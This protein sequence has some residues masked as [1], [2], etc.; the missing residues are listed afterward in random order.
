MCGCSYPCLE[1]EKSNPNA[2]SRNFCKCVPTTV[3][4]GGSLIVVGAEH[5]TWETSEPTE[6]YASGDDV[7]NGVDDGDPDAFERV[8]GY[9]Q[10]NLLFGT[11]FYFYK[12]ENMSEKP[13]A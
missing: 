8:D 12:V 11:R 13:Y 1:A 9:F 7:G 6:G 10:V 2:R 3:V 4:S 5:G